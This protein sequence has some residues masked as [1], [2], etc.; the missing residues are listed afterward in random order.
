MKSSGRSDPST[1][2][3][4]P[5]AHPPSSRYRIQSTSFEGL[6]LLSDELVRRLVAYH[7]SIESGGQRGGGG[8]EEEEPFAVLYAE[9]LP[10]QEYFELIDSHLHCRAELDGHMAELE[11][12]AQ[13]FRIV[14]KRL[15]VRL[16]DRNPAPIGNLEL[17]SEGTYHQLLDL[18]DRAS[19]AHDALQFQRTRLS[20]G[21]RLIHLLL[22]LRPPPSTPPHPTP[23][24][25]TPERRHAADPPA[26]PATLLSIDR[27]F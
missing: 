9:P 4:H 6:W 10:L 11:K 5:R 13:Q 16:K 2:R 1:P 20:A 19:A 24:H 23:P 8:G 14:E 12:R 18:S 25:P 15:L 7:H 26:A 22:R 27:R 21:T 17:L 3:A